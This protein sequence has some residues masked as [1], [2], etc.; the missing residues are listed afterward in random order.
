MKCPQCNASLGR[1]CVVD[2]DPLMC[3]NCGWGGANH[4]A[5]AAEDDGPSKAFWL[6][7][8]FFWVMTLVVLVGPYVGLRFGAAYVAGPTGLADGSLEARFVA[9]LNLHYAWVMAVY[10]AF[11]WV[12]TPTYDR[13]NMGLF[14]RGL[15]YNPVLT[16]EHRYNRTMHKLNTLVTPGKIVLATCRATWGLR[17]R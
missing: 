6:K 16:G 12:V 13:E 4:S 2:A 5:D 8:A 9:G 15:A 7:F 1:R 17:R 11:C 10:L 14:G 3:Q